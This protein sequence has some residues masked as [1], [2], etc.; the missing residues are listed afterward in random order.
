MTVRAMSVL[1]TALFLMSVGLFVVGVP[2]IAIP[3]CAYAMFGALILVCIRT[4][5]SR[6]TN[7]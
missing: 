5:D 3:L 2:A 7:G 6:A 1:V 4:G